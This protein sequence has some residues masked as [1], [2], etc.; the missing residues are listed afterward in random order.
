M[1]LAVIVPEG[2]GNYIAGMRHS[3]QLTG[4]LLHIQTKSIAGSRIQV[5]CGGSAMLCDASY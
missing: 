3:L 1:R 2:V 5:Q 4:Y